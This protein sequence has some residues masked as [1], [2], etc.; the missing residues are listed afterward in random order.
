MNTRAVNI[1]QSVYEEDIL[2][3]EIIQVINRSGSTFHVEWKSR[4]FNVLCRHFID[5]PSSYYNIFDYCEETL[6]QVF[7]RLLPDAPFTT[8]MICN[9]IEVDEDLSLTSKDLTENNLIRLNSIF[10]IIHGVNV[11]EF[12]TPCKVNN[13][14]EFLVQ[15]NR[16][17]HRL[18]FPESKVPSLVVYDGD[19]LP[20]I[21]LIADRVLALEEGELEEIPVDF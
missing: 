3:G 15:L 12:K 11:L 5:K 17:I 16:W 8:S 6:R 9:L 18:K 19:H 13:F 20:G 4:A 7:D 2:P 1:K 14:S 10:A 21:Y